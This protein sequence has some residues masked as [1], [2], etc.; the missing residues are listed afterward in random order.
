MR[1]TKSIYST[2]E[3]SSIVSRNYFMPVMICLFFFATAKF[4][5]FNILGIKRELLYLIILLTFLVSVLKIDYLINILKKR[6]IIMLTLYCIIF[7]RLIRFNLDMAIL[8]ITVTAM[9]GFIFWFS[10]KTFDF[11]FK[12][13]IVCTGIFSFLV[14]IQAFIYIFIPGNFN[15]PHAPIPP[16]DWHPLELL[17]INYPIHY[18]GF[19]ALGR[20][21]LLGV[22]L[23][24][25]NSF[26]SEPAIL[27]STFL[28]P[29][30]LGLTYRGTIRK[31]SYV[32]L[33]FSIILAF[34]GTIY[35]SLAV[36]FIVFFSLLIFQFFLNNKFKPLILFGIIIVYVFSAYLIIKT[37]IFT[38]VNMMDVYLGQYSHY[39][40][41]LGHESKPIA[42][43]ISSQKAVGLL[44]AHPF[45][46]SAELPISVTGL[47]LSYGLLFGFFGLM[48]CTIIF[49]III[50]KLIRAFYFK[51]GL[52]YKIGISLTIG[53]LIQTL[54]FSGYGWLAPS[55]LIMTSLLYVRS[56]NLLNNSPR[57]IIINRVKS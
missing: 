47:L 21:Y 10:Q 27:T 48:L 43:V 57:I 19:W 20:E 4:Y 36:G 34:A 40:S 28:I 37:D 11:T 14:L 25:F 35:L 46:T 15:V 50:F 41:I 3:S 29:G 54:F 51:L 44:I 1:I 45:G 24:R 39:S 55:G 26:A 53:T 13:I 56:S 16:P 32:V 8:F 22:E 17:A 42:R 38:I 18:L 5:F 9:I 2:V 6:N 30:L 49:T 33:F 31:I 52:V 12:L 23:P 7:V